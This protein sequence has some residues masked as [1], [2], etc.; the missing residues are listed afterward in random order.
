MTTLGTFSPLVEPLSLDEAFVDMT[1]CEALFGEPRAMGEAVRRGRPRS[2]R[3]HRLGRGLDHQVR[4][5]GRERPPQTRRPDRRQ[6][7]RG[8]GLS[9]PA[10]DRS[11]LGGG[12]AHVRAAPGPRPRHHRRRRND[13][14]RRPGTLVRQPRH[15]HPCPRP[16]PRRPR[17]DPGARREEHRL[18]EH[19]RHRHRREGR[20]PP[21]A[22]ARGRHRRAPAPCRGSGRARC[23]GEAAHRRLPAAY[24]ADRPR[25]RDPRHAADRGGGGD[26]AP[27]V[28]PA[29]PG[30]P[31]RRRRVRPRGS[32]GRGRS[33]SARPVS[34]PRARSTT[35][36][37]TGPSTWCT[38]ASATPP[39]PAPGTWTHRD[40]AI[41]AVEPSVA[42][43]VPGS[44][45]V[46]P[47]W[48]MAGL[49]PACGRDARAPGKTRSA[50]RNPFMRRGGQSG[51][52][53][54]P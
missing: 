4:G 35:S 25:R 48:T 45:G 14:A 26:S 30:A 23:A 3:P 28:R 37:S 10:A 44:A 43:G 53:R 8:D 34:T 32:R 50:T 11:P 13:R 46:P 27:R 22:A 2:D 1:G 15:P 52:A 54:L 6:S 47:A 40:A 20:D 38:S 36:G 49:R 9:S 39:S 5:E 12:R 24:P 41:L 17:G 21:V 42:R 18:G 7:G 29:R 51:H 19:A 31:R 16:R 33:P